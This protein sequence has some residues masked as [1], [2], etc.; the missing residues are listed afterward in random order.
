MNSMFTNLQNDL[1]NYYGQFM[2][3]KLYVEDQEL[4]DKYM[5]SIDKHHLNMSNDI[6]HID[7]GFDLWNPEDQIIM[8]D[9]VNKM[10]F[11]VMCSAKIIKKISSDKNVLNAYNT[12][13][14]NSGFYMYPRSSISKTK[15]R[16][17]NN[18]G[19]IDSGYRGCLIGMF[20]VIYSSTPIQVNKHERF[21]QI[22]SPDVLPIVVELVD[23]K[24][25]LGLNT[26]RGSGGFGSTGV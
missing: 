23:K 9:K 22:V 3:L 12:K 14:Y 7:A 20:D 19:I 8:S 10:D 18:V 2:Y 21:L 6:Q 5:E 11:K 13:Q 1:L 15:L 17:A 24:T 25:D 26:S 4:K 16:L